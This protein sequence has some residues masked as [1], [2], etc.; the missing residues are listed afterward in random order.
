[1]KF[2][3]DANLP[4][5]SAPLLLGLGHSVEDVREVLPPG[6]DD[7]TVAARAQSQRSVL[8]SRDF[9]FAD[10]RNYPPETYSGLVVLELPDD[11]TAAQVNKTLE[12]FVRNPDFLDRLPG[13]LAIVSS[14]RVRFR[15]A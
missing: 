8:I 1:M 15:P 6:A 13:R 14:W 5:S 7:D 4:R 12:T 10:I 11:A 2:L 9:D 3:L